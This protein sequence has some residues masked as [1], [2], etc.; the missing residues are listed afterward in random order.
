MTSSFD[1]GSA[2]SRLPFAST[3]LSTLVRRDHVDTRNLGSIMLHPKGTGNT[4][5]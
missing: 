3:E 1:W 4:V 5:I 2:W